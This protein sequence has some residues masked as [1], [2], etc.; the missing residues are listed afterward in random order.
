MKVMSP[1][2]LRTS[3]LIFAWASD[4]GSWL[5]RCSYESAMPVRK[6]L[7]RRAGPMPD[8]RADGDSV[9]FHLDVAGVH[10]NARLIIRCD[11]NGNVWIS[12]IPERS[13]DA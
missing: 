12:I 5:T 6:T 7:D 13:R 10:Q 9:T 4:A 11:G 1:G 8:I 2:A 3:A